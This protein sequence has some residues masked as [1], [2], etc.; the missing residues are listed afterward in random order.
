[1]EHNFVERNFA[2]RFLLGFGVIMAMAVV[3]ERLG[4][5]LL[6]YGVPYGDWIGV[7][8]GAIG[9]FIAFAAVYTRFDSVYEDRL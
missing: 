8:V 2:V 1:M 6:E 7:A 3:G 5:G 9:V 4:I